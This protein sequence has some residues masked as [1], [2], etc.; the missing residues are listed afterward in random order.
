MVELFFDLVFVFAVTQL[1]HA[2]VAHLT[3][4]G[5]AQTGL[6]LLAVW[7]VWIS[8]SWVTNWLDPERIPVRLAVLA[9]MFAGLLMSVSIPHAFDSRGLLFA[10]AFVAMQVGRTLFFLWAVRREHPNMRRNFQRILI[11]LCVSSACWIAG[12][13]STHDVRFGWWA[14]ALV[15]ESIAPLAYFWVPGL[16]RSAIKDWDVE[17]AHLAERCALFI[18]IALGESLLVTGATFAALEW[19]GDTLAAFANA[20]L[21]TILLWWLYFDTGARRATQRIESARDPGREG[22]SAY[23]YA[24]ILIVA[25]VIG[26]AVADEVVLAHPRHVEGLGLALVIGGPIV[27]LAGTSIF[28]WITND[29]RAPPLSHLIGLVLLGAVSYTHLRAHET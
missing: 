3:P 15:I 13:F 26:C 27:F 16:G 6:L 11:W 20:V 17:G 9:L 24:H 4:T 23:T 28:K 8:T 10:S 12:A 14:L 5:I 29:R 2:L 21:G 19:N 25:G 7:W 1:S 22:R 18:I